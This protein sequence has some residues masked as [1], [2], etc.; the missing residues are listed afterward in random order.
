VAARD[1]TSRWI[2]SQPA[3]DDA[4]LLRA[5][6]DAVVVGAGTLRA[7]DPMLSSRV[8]GVSHQPRPVIVAGRSA[9]PPDRR[10][11][12]RDPIVI[13]A[14]GLEV[15]S[16]DLLPV[17]AGPDGLPDPEA[18]ARALADNGLYDILLEGGPELA[19]AWWR[20]GVV[21]RGVF[22]VAGRVA[23]GQGLSPLGG[24]FETMAQ[25]REVTVL[26]VRMV[27]P[28]MRIEFA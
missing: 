21:D 1:G 24:V 2:T 12:G 25:S 6:M 22:Y 28:D 26:E 16:G 10:V 23:G 20:A 17:D 13:G 18:S 7:D 3:R 15:P 11:W 27:G 4:H 9:L 8:D 14:P 19:G 5:G